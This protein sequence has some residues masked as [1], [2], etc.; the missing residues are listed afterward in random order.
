MA[1][2]E[3][4]LNLNVETSE[5]EIKGKFKFTEDELDKVSGGVEVQSWWK[6]VQP[7]DSCG[8][9]QKEE[10]KVTICCLISNTGPIIPETSICATCKH[11][12]FASGKHY[13]TLED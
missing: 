9:W 13:C 2:F 12:T 5:I 6:V 3:G 11:Y 10:H 4:K 8:S 1:E 7:T